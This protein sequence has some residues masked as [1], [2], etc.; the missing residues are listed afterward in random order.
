[1]KF[2]Q[3]SKRNLTLFGVLLLV[4]ALVALSLSST[5]FGS[6]SN[7]STHDGD[8]PHDLAGESHD[9]HHDLDS[10][11]HDEHDGD[12]PHDLAGESH[13]DHHDLA[14]DNHDDDSNHVGE[15]PHDLA[16]ESHENHSDLEGHDDDK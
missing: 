3:V 7:G 9:D 13:E 11:E 5:V 1:M 14:D 8:H 6:D 2:N 12:H 10:G 16:G 15:H 4:A